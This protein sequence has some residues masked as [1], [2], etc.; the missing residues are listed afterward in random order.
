MNDTADPRFRAH[1]DAI[2]PGLADWLRAIIEAQ[3]AA[4]CVD[5]EHAR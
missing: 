4:E 1:Y 3:A 5:V 2:E